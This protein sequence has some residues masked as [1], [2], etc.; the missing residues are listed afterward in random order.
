MYCMTWVGHVKDQGIRSM[1]NRQS[2]SFRSGLGRQNLPLV[3]VWVFTKDWPVCTEAS[4]CS[5]L[6]GM[7]SLRRLSHRGSLSLLAGLATPTPY[8]IN[9]PRFQTVTLL[10]PLHQE[11][12]HPPSP[13][14]PSYS[15]CLSVL[16]LL[17]LTLVRVLGPSHMDG[18]S[19]NSFHPSEIQCGYKLILFLPLHAHP[20]LSS[21]FPFISNLF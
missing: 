17:P 1:R 15:V 2:L 21:L 20:W 13:A 16:F 8:I 19:P 3:Q 9:A 12:A 10:V 5:F 7:Y 14:Y 18:R 6:L 4:E 11:Y